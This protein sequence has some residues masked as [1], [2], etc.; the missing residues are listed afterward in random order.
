MTW[1]YLICAGLFEVVWAT[2]MKLSQGFTD[3][4]YTSIMVITMLASV[5]LLALAIKELP[6]GIAYPVW[7]GI[8]AVGSIIVGVTFFGDQLSPLTWLFVVLLLIGLI[9]IKVTSGH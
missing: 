6:L 1:I 8:G 5:G 2:T 3:L 9:G 7:T 4:K